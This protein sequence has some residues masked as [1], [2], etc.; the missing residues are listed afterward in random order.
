[1]QRPYLLFLGDVHDQLAAKTAD[2]IAYW[3][4]EWCVGQMR[5]PGCQA[6][7][8]L[9]D[10]T[11]TEAAAKGAKTLVVA[12]ANSGGVL[13]AHW[14][15]VLTEAMAAGMDIASGLH[16]RLSSIPAVAEAAAKHG[17]QLHDV[18]HSDQ[19]FK[20]GTGLK[21]A[22]KRLLTVGT[23]CSV[24]KKYS[25]LAITKAMEA[26]GMDVSFCATGQTGVMIAERGVAID[27][28]IADF[29]SGAVEWLSPEADPNHWDVIEGQG[30]LFHAAF[31]GVTLGL[32]HGAQ[33]DA[34]VLCHEPT[35][36]HMRGLKHAPIPRL[37]ECFR[38]YVSL[39]TLTNPDAQF[40]G[41]CVDTHLLSPAEADRYLKEQ[42]DR[43][44]LPCVDPLAG[45]A[46]PIVDRLAS[47]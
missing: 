21:R 36:T 38:P 18:R 5:L 10:L 24:G 9:P 17:S 39:A 14:A 42:E 2:G 6:D 7:V 41:I 44:G 34:L 22:G 1:M 28:V 12:V 32:L 31:S 43:F 4:P 16:T 25:A 23:D 47:L 40:V 30:S 3:R 15:A 33:P 20:T 19:T 46:S 27:A 37:E 29:I 26:R 35:R 13:P 8:G 45:D 11:V